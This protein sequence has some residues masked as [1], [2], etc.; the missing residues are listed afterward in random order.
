MGAARQRE[1]IAACRKPCLR[2]MR[3]WLMPSGAFGL[4][5]AKAMRTPC[6]LLSAGDGALPRAFG[7]KSIVKVGLGSS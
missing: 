5:T 2:K 1:R 3:P 7:P 6:N 4:A